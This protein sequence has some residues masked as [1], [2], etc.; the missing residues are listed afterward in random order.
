MSCERGLTALLGLLIK[1]HK[2]II[3]S[4][5]RAA[6]VLFLSFNQIWKINLVRC[7]H[8]VG[9]HTLIPQTQQASKTCNVVFGR[10]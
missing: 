2:E 6:I 3:R 1:G 8:L 4:I 5:T 9:L 7:F 10:K